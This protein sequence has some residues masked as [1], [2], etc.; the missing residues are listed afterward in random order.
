MFPDIKV[1]SQQ[2]NSTEAIENKLKELQEVVSASLLELVDAL[3]VLR[4]EMEKSV[5]N[6]SLKD[7]V[8]IARRVKIIEKVV[9]IA[10]FDLRSCWIISL[11]NSWNQS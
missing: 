5:A 1:N 3:K 9:L 2:F 10:S 4:E 11:Q 6:D 8:Q 7:C